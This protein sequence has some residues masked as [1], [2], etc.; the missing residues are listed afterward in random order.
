M[1]VMYCI[2]CGADNLEAA[3]FCRKC[4]A[5]VSSQQ[6]GAEAE[7][8]TRVATRQKAENGERRT[9][10]AD[11][12]RTD[13]AEIFSIRPTLMFVKVGYVLA[14]IGA[15]FSVLLWWLVVPVVILLA[16]AAMIVIGRHRVVTAA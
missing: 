2:K 7:E 15:V 1:P 10:N 9:E 11:D 8:E 6:S 5:D 12:T 14:A 3:K 4:G 16:G 13:E